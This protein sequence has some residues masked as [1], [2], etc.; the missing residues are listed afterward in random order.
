VE[1]PRERSRG[2]VPPDA[3]RDGRLRAVLPQSRGRNHIRE[4]DLSKSFP[5]PPFWYSFEGS[6]ADIGGHAVAAIAR[7][8]RDYG[9]A[10]GI[11]SSKTRPRIMSSSTCTTW[12]F[13]FRREISKSAVSDPAAGASCV[14]RTW[15]ARAVTRA[16]SFPRAAR[17]Q[18]PRV[19]PQLPDRLAGYRLKFRWDVRSRRRSLHIGVRL[20]LAEMLQQLDLPLLNVP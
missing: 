14:S 18:V 10:R 17:R 8:C 20:P 13:G 5:K 12:R 2:E 11:A 16:R 15:Y 1:N 6:M 19:R 3:S 4:Q 7:K 9:A